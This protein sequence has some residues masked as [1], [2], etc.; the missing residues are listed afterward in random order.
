[1]QVPL[2]SHAFIHSKD[3][4]LHQPIDYISN[5]RWKTLKR[6]ARISAASHGLYSK[7]IRFQFFFSTRCTIL[8][9]GQTHY[10]K[11]AA[12][13][14]TIIK[15][16]QFFQ[17]RQKKNKQTHKFWFIYLNKMMDC[18][19][20]S[21]RF[22]KHLSVDHPWRGLN[23]VVSFRQLTLWRPSARGRSSSH[24]NEWIISNSQRIFK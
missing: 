11:R 19:Q 17:K 21:L 6:V 3:N 8:N 24:S 4:I 13:I 1:M 20:F 5:H 10:I 2:F 7:F 18:R 14:A 12:G 16:Q 15:T 23:I 22:W 9:D